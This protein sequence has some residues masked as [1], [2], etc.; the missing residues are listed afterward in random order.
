MVE[1]SSKPISEHAEV[2]LADEGRWETIVED[3]QARGRLK[4]TSGA[5]GNDSYVV[6]VGP[7]RDS[8]GA[9]RAA[10]GDRQLGGEPGGFGSSVRRFAT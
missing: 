2:P 5:G 4:S 1:F 6:S 7:L 3:W 8:A 9:R 10:R